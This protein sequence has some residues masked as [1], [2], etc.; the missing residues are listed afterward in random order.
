MP[1]FAGR[2]TRVHRSSD[3]RKEFAAL[4]RP[5]PTHGTLSAILTLPHGPNDTKRRYQTTFS[6]NPDI[7]LTKAVQPPKELMPLATEP[8]TFRIQHSATD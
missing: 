3:N 2:V 4:T 7:H 5:L 8:Y 6:L 1:S